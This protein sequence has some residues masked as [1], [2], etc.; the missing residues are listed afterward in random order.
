MLCVCVGGAQWAWKVLVL[1]VLAYKNFATYHVSFFFFF[2]QNTTTNLFVNVLLAFLLYRVRVWFGFWF[3]FGVQKLHFEYKKLLWL[4]QLYLYIV[5]IYRFY[6]FHFAI[7]FIKSFTHCNCICEW[8]L[9][10][11]FSFD[12]VFWF[13][14]LLCLC[15]FGWFLVSF[16]LVFGFVCLFSFLGF[17]LRLVF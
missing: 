5:Y 3:F 12:L 7:R 16:I 4:I 1:V 15:K 9:L 17:L 13:L 10:W 2:L 11:E 8:F 14:C 6:S